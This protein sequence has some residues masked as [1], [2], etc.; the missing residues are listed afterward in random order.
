VAIPVVIEGTRRG[1]V[2]LDPGY[3]VA[4]AVVAMEDEAYPHTGWFTHTKNGASLKEYCYQ[5]IDSDDR[6]LAWNVRET[7]HGVS[8]EWSNLIYVKRAFEKCLNITEKRSLFYSF[9]SL[10]IRDRKGP[11]AGIY[12]WMKSNT[13]TVFYPENNERK[14]VKLSLD[15]IGTEA[16]EVPLKRL[17]KF[18]SGTGKE[19]MTT[20]MLVTMLKA[21]KS[22]LKDQSFVSEMIELDDWIED[23]A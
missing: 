5:V 22:A 20:Q 11:T 3:H 15:T 2:V 19:R 14:Q 23:E 8:N 13:I 12:C 18:M 16:A 7:R 17:A 21:F 9:K 4:R 6:F 10:V 1:Y